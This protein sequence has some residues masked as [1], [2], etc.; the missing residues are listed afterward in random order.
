MGQLREVRGLTFQILLEHTNVQRLVDLTITTFV[1]GHDGLRCF[2]FVGSRV[3][4]W[5]DRNIRIWMVS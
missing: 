4:L 5:S 1:F 3:Y 2:D